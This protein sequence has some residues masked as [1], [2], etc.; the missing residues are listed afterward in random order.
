MKK[1]R[2]E[3]APKR[4]MPLCVVRWLLSEFGFA[5]ERAERAVPTTAEALSYLDPREHLVLLDA[6]LAKEHECAIRRRARCGVRVAVFATAWDAVREAARARECAS[7]SVLI[8]AQSEL[9]RAEHAWAL[10]VLAQHARGR[11]VFVYAC[12]LGASAAFRAAV[13]PLPARVLASTN[14]T[15]SGAAADWELEYCSDGGAPSAAERTHAAAALF[16]CPEQLPATLR[17]G[18]PTRKKNTEKS[19]TGGPIKTPG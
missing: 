6:A 15:G 18:Q 13:E 5:C 17:L 19:S 8:D 10:G 12:G 11:R 1:G 2:Q 3:K 14:D 7:V 4:K 16:H 9:A